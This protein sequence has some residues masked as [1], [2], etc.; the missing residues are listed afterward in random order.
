MLYTYTGDQTLVFTSIKKANGETL[1]A[2][3]GETY[4]LETTP[5]DPRFATSTEG[6]LALHS[7]PSVE[8]PTE[9]TQES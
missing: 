9:P 8:P 3:P 1:L 6:S 2:V 4:D 7:E 5:D